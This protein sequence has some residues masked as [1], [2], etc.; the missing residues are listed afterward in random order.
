MFWPHVFV[1]CFCGFFVWVVSRL[2]GDSPMSPLLQRVHCHP[3]LPTTD[4]FPKHQ[5]CLRCLCA[6]CRFAS[7][8]LWKAVVCFQPP[9]LL[10]GNVWVPVMRFFVC[11]IHYKVRMR[12]GRRLGSCRLISAQP[13][14]GSTIMKFY[15]SSVLREL[16]VLCCLY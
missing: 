2:A 9:S 5:Y 15:I 6:W 11:R 12:V 8:D 10:I 4:R 7:D 3:Q 16:E 14:V 13:L 1:S